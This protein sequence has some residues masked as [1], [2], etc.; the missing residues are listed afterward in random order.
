[1][2]KSKVIFEEARKAGINIYV[3]RITR[4]GKIHTELCTKK[5]KD[6]NHD[7]HS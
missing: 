5:K 7:I 6:K 2:S 1:M 4:D 3:L